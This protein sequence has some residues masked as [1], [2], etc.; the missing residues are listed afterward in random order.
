MPEFRL[1]AG[2]IGDV[3]AFFKTLERNAGASS[4]LI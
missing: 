1:D 3:I 2:Q 4:E